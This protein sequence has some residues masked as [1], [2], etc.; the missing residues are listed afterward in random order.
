MSDKM[1][2]PYLAS[3][4]F[5]WHAVKFC[6]H[7]DRPC[8]CW[9]A[10][11]KI[12]YC[13]LFLKYRTSSSLMNFPVTIICFNSL[14]LYLG[15]NL[16]GCFRISFT[17]ISNTLQCS[18]RFFDF[19]IFWHLLA[20]AKSFMMFTFSLILAVLRQTA[21]NSWF[22]WAKPQPRNNILTMSSFCAELCVL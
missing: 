8:W 19:I 21:T 12:W 11:G 7:Q 10:S 9:Y 4:T 5:P 15:D 14:L 6:P 17:R 13:S 2:N 16:V 20:V 3:K 1:S 18:L 22:S